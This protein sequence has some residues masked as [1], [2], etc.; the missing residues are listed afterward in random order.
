MGCV[1]NI[2]F[3]SASDDW[4]DKL[5]KGGVALDP[6]PSWTD[7]KNRERKPTSFRGGIASI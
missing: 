3:G 1:H 7:K 4:T 2:Q 6:R 5:L